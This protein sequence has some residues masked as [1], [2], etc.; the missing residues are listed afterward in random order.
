MSLMA[1]SHRRF[2]LPFHSLATRSML[3]QRVRA[4]VPPHRVRPVPR[5]PT[6]PVPFRHK[7]SPKLVPAG[8]FLFD[9]LLSA[10]VLVAAVVSPPPVFPGS[11]ICATSSLPI[12]WNEAASMC[13]PAGE[14]QCDSFPDLSSFQIFAGEMAE[15]LK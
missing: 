10:V 5:I 6:R 11:P 2:L 3:R 9:A 8:Y 13:V 14:A 1:S 7:N 12:E 4:Q 15:W